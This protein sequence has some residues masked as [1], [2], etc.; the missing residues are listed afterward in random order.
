MS[1]SSG[2]RAEILAAV[3]QAL[4]AA[5]RS[6]AVPTRPAYANSA[7]YAFTHE[8]F[9]V[10]LA[11]LSCAEAQASS[12]AQVPAIVASHLASLNLAAQ[13][14]IEPGQLS[15]LAWAKAGLSV[16]STW[17]EDARVA[18][19]KC[20]AAIAETGQ[21]LI[22]S[23]TAG[24]LLSLLPEYHIA[25]LEAAAIVPSLDNLGALL[26]SEPPGTV[27]LIAGPSRTADIQLELVI[28]AHGPRHM[29]VIVIAAPSSS[30]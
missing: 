25:V 17:T 28:G 6:L 24:S 1:R 12:L 15:E 8:H 4:G 14:V 30:D 29:L 21:V 13:A 7:D 18:V 9:S 20:R 23:T 26:G 2:S 27:T 11:A 3:R 5:P 22:D 16:S 10:Q 19:C